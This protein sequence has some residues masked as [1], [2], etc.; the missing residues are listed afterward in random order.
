M[1]TLQQPTYF[2]VKSGSYPAA[3]QWTSTVLATIVI[4]YSDL[5]SDN[6]YFSNVVAFYK[7]QPVANLTFQKNDDKLWVVLTYLRGAAYAAVHE[8]QWV[9][10]FLSRA[11]WFYM[12]ASTGW[13]DKNCGGGMYWGPCS[14]YKNAVTTELWISASMGMYEAFKEEKMLES[15]IRG[16]VWFKNSGLINNAGLVNDGLDSNCKYSLF[17]LHPL[18]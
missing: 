12:L 15:A 14:N 7:N 11:K 16:W 13:D 3:V 1:Q 18:I 9:K 2:T 17:H 4:D 6:R 8:K 10:P 5:T